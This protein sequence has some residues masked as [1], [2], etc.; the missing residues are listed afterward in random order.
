M[1]K[2]TTFIGVEGEPLAQHT[3]Q[4]STG[5]SFPQRAN[6][7]FTG[8]VRVQDDGDND[9]TIVEIGSP[10]VDDLAAQVAALESRIAALEA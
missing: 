6:L 10:N 2:Y 7:K 5:D 3:I 4:N 8:N 1:T 9:A